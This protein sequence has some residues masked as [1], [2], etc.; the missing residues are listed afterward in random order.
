MDLKL[1]EG[2]FFTKGQ[3]SD[4]TDGIIVNQEY[5]NRFR[6]DL[7]IG[8]LV[9]VGDEKRYIIGV[10][11]NVID[12]VWSDNYMIPKLYIPAK[13]NEYTKLLVKADLDKEEEVFAYLQDSWKEVIPDRPFTGR[14]Q[15]DVAFGN[16]LRENNNMKTIFLSLA[17]LGSLLS[18]TGIFALSSLNVSSRFKEIGIR[19][20]M[21]ASSRNILV[22]MN[23]SFFWVMSVATII[24]AG[25]GYVVTDAVLKIMYSYHIQI[26]IGTLL[27]SGLTIFLVAIVTTTFTILSAANTNPAYILRDE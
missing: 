2:R 20:V 22:Q 25:L 27:I 17:I 16:A 7:V 9:Q 13:E 1:V 14:Y 12:Y 15:D 19:K 26:G 11:G 24:G 3:E 21:G 6:P 8:S 4:F 10:V 5:V 18:L 23:R